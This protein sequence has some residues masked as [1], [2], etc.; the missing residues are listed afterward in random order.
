MIFTASNKKYAEAIV[1]KIDP[2]RHFVKK[3]LYRSSCYE[4]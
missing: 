3:V 1:D 4:A 2:N